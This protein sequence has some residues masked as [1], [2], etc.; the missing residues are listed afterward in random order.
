MR[1]KDYLNRIEQTGFN[2]DDL[3]VIK[4]YILSEGRIE[5]FS[6]MYIDLL[7]KAKEENEYLESARREITMTIPSIHNKNYTVE[8][9]N[10]IDELELDYALRGNFDNHNIKDLKEKISNMELPTFGFIDII[11]YLYKH[12]GIKFKNSGNN[13]YIMTKDYMMPRFRMIMDKRAELQKKKQEMEKQ[14]MMYQVE[15]EEDDK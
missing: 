5:D 8:E 7:T 6:S 14:Y 13:E 9:N 4:D 10:L 3:Y 1:L 11:T 12:Y 15:D 2:F